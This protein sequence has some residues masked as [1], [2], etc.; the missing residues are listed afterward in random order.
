MN[1][2][3]N[4]EVRDQLPDLLHERLEPAVRAAVM[5][6]VE[7]CADCRAELELLRGVHLM[8]AKATP[9]VDVGRIVE[10]LPRRRPARSR[11]MDWRIAAAAVLIAVGGAS[12]TLIP[13]HG[14][15]LRPDT[16]AVVAKAETPNAPSSVAVPD[17]QPASPRVDSQPSRVQQVAAQTSDVAVDRGI[18]MTGGLSELSE[19]EL[20][21]LL[22]EIDE[23]EAVPLTE[24]EPAVI[25]VTSKRSGSPTGT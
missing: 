21:L 5:T 20:R 23:L 16:T 18:E 25:P 19:D 22:Q 10:A 4:A 3:V 7:G 8:L 13:R 1:D 9:S 14:E 2:C 11:W 17:R 15:Q 6:H 24:P 12:A